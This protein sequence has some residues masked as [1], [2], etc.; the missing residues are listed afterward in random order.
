MS[1]QSAVQGTGGMVG[2]S[3]AGMVSGILS[4]LC[5]CFP[6]FSMLLGIAALVLGFISLKNRYDGKGMAI[7]G[8]V[9]GGIGTFLAILFIIANNFSDVLFEGLEDILGF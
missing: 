8:M 9:C 1:G 7:A 6:Y 5:C 3:V 2:I 4:L